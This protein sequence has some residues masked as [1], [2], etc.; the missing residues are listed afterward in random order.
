M[1]CEGGV[2]PLGCVSFGYRLLLGLKVYGVVGGLDLFCLRAWI[3]AL[4]SFFLGFP[5]R[6]IIGSFVPL[7]HKA[8]LHRGVSFI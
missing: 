6:R 5:R 8:A 4:S 1:L 2:W 3:I 7:F